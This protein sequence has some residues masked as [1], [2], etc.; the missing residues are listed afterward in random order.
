MKLYLCEK[1]SQANDIAS[2]LGLKNKTKSHIV[3][4]DGVVTWA[5]GHLLELKSPDEYDEKYSAWNWEN[6]PIFPEKFLI[7]I[8]SG[9]TEQVKAIKGLLK[10]ASEVVIS[11]DADREG[12]MIAREVLDYC[13]YRGKISRLWLSALD[14]ESIKKALQRLK[15]DEETRPLYFAAMARSRAD[16]LV[17]MNMSRAMTVRCSNGKGG[18]S[19]GRVQTPTL[20]LVVRRDRD[21]ANFVPRDYFEI[22]ATVDTR[23]TSAKDCTVVLKHAPDGEKRMFEKAVADEIA[24]RVIG[25]EGDLKVEKEV[26]KQ[27]PP[28]LFSLAGLQ[29]RCSALYGW[30]ADDTL[31]IAQSLYE[32]HKVT[33]YPRSD[34]EFLPEEQEGDISTILEN[35][36]SANIFA[37]KIEKPIIRKTVFNTGKITA[38]HAIIPT[39]VKPNLAKLSEDERKAYVLI[40]KSYVA[41]L[42]PDYEYEQTRIV[43]EAD[44]TD[45]KATGN[46]PLKLGWKVIY[47]QAESKDKDALLPSIADG[48]PGKITKATVEAKQTKPPDAYTEGTL[49]ADMKAVGKFVTDPEKKKILKETSGIGTEATRAS[50]IKRLRSAEFLK[51]SGKKIVST[52]K[53]KTLIALLEKHLPSLADPGETAVWEDGFES[54]VEGKATTDKFLKDIEGVITGYLGVLGKATPAP[55]PQSEKPKMEMIE[56]NVLCP[57]SGKPVLDAGNR[58]VFGVEGWFSK[59]VSRRNMSAEDYARILTAKEPVTFNGFISTKTGNTFSAKLFYNP[60]R[61]YL[62]KLS[63]GV[64]F[65]FD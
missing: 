54:I 13:G 52:E 29:M 17:G 2:V 38:H 48:T 15:K 30:S 63:P 46:V 45:F 47:A 16:W 18:V 1:P 37:G 51:A 49:I 34:C 32:S 11:T 39:K 27:A 58:W 8:S 61:K 5:F 3:T 24:K 12:E 25:Y 19:I 53:G 62:K 56:T 55:A 44:K 31:K 64:E 41:A 22:V 43:L 40:A 50:I 60:N 7:K 35:L 26:K 20:A 10:E 59:V 9:K 6:L 21:I 28:K 33:T 57:K 36:S 4:N 14:P 42:L 23:D 65:K